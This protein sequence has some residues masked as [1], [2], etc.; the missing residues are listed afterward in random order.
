MLPSSLYP[1]AEH[2]VDFNFGAVP[3]F[4]ATMVDGISILHTASQVSCDMI[5]S[6]WKSAPQSIWNQLMNKGSLL[7]LVLGMLWSN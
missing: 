3:L 7:S 1:F 6:G 2:E 5:W 4:A